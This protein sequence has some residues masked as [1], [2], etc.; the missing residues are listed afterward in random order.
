MG[1]DLYLFTFISPVAKLVF[2]TGINVSSGNVRHQRTVGAKKVPQDTSLAHSQFPSGALT[3][4][5]GGSLA[6]GLHTPSSSLPRREL[7]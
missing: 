3:P 7:L 4:E 6:L 5:R 1:R 2:G